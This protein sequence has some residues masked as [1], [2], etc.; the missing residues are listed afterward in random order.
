TTATDGGPGDGVPGP[1]RAFLDNPGAPADA[2]R[3]EGPAA[4]L[5]CRDLEVV[6]RPGAD[7]AGAHDMAVAFGGIIRR[8]R[9][10]AIDDGKMHE[11]VEGTDRLVVRHM[12]V[13]LGSHDVGET[14]VG[15]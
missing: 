11:R 14:E 4:V 1:E 7:G 15:S 13:R 2:R 6:S 5:E 3:V 8:R 12:L 9:A 10:V